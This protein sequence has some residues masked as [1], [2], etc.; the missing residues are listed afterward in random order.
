MPPLIPRPQPPKVL[1]KGSL[2]N[3]LKI[4]QVKQSLLDLLQHSKDHRDAMNPILQWIELDINDPKSFVNFVGNIKM[5][6]KPSITFNDHEVKHWKEPWG[7]DPLLHIIANID[8]KIFKRIL[9]DEGFAI[10]IISTMAFKKLNIPLSHI[11]APTL[12][13]KVFNDALCPTVGSISI[14]IIVGSKIVQTI[15]LVIKG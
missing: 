14:P 2:Q 9:I 12:Q 6:Q 3:Q 1:I 15:L 8:G 11:N 13:L 10:N 7:L 4:S 5:L